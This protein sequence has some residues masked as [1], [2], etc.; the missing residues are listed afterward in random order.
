[1]VGRTASWA[2][3]RVVSREASREASQAASRAVSRVVSRSAGR[4]ARQP[5]C[6]AV[7]SPSA[8]VVA[9]IDNCFFLDLVVTIFGFW[10]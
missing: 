4:A 6:E 8:R 2:A 10:F 5:G 3:S 7:G 1:M 9:R